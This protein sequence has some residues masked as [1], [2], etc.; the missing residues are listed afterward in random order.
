MNKNPKNDAKID[1]K[2][3]FFSSLKIEVIFCKNPRLT[4]G[5]SLFAKSKKL[6]YF[7]LCNGISS[8][9]LQTL[10]ATMSTI[11][12]NQTVE[13]AV[14]TMLNKHASDAVK[15]LSEKYGFPLEEALAELDLE[16]ARVTKK[17]KVAK[18]PKEEA[19]AAKPKDED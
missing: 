2:Y 15:M 7:L 9:H 14:K 19:K 3:K 4:L 1:D 13:T 6:K 11:A 12:I 10:Q 8:T 5:K 18:E 17:E 16:N